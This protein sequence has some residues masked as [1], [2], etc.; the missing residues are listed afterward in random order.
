LEK[1]GPRRGGNPER[2]KARK[3]TNTRKR[4][5]GG[6]ELKTLWN[7]RRKK[8]GYLGKILSSTERPHDMRNW[9]GNK[10]N[11]LKKKHRK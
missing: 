1:K 9:A 11:I 5:H 6:L 4:L 7:P 8:R 3:K 2:E 10:R